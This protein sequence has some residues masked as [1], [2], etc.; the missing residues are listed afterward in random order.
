MWTSALTLALAAMPAM[1]LAAPR[2]PH[3]MNRRA[4]ETLPIYRNSSYCVSER[5]EALIKRMTVEENAGQLFHQRLYQ[6]DNGTLFGGSATMKGTV[7]ALG[8]M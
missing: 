3:W 2:R 5:V 8:K 4:D 1:T 7:E 6:G